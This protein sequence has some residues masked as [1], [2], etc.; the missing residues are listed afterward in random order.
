MEI[1]KTEEAKKEKSEEAPKPEQPAAEG[2]KKSDEPKAE[3]ESLPPPHP[4]EIVLKVYMHCDVLEKSAVVSTDLKDVITDCRTSKVIVRGEKADPLKVLERVQ[5]KSHR[6]ALLISPIPKPPADELKKTEDKEVDK[7]EEKKEELIVIT[8]VLGVYMHCEACAQEIKKRILR[9]KDINPIMMLFNPAEYGP[10]KS[11][12]VASFLFYLSDVEEGG[13][14]MF[15]FE[16][17]QNMDGSYD[18]QK[19]IGLKVKPHKGDGLLFY[20]LYPNGT[21]DPT[22]LHGSCPVIKGENWV[23]TKRIRNQDQDEEID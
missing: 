3:E 8:A 2:E 6:Q 9:M 21:I 12:R 1:K 20:S 23:T 5:R 13:E 16:N 4:L 17:G 7:V 22:S 10:Q 14:T 11:Q 18:F 15:P 19:C